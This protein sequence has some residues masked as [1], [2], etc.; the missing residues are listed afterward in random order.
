MASRQWKPLRDG[1]YV[2]NTIE[3]DRIAMTVAD[4]G[5]WISIAGPE[6]MYESINFSPFEVRLCQLVK[7]AEDATPTVVMTPER[8][9]ALEEVVGLAEYDLDEGYRRDAELKAAATLLRQIL[10]ELKA[11]NANP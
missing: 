11:D 1:L 2:H 5:E 10:A 4:N 3:G 6:D 7:T 9:E 8:V